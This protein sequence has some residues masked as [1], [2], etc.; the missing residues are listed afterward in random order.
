MAIELESC[1]DEPATIEQLRAAVDEHSR[2][3]FLD[4]VI[5]EAIDLDTTAELQ[6]R[7]HAL[8]DR[9]ATESEDAQRWIRGA[10]QYFIESNDAS[11][12]FV[13]G[14]LEDDRAVMD[15]V[16]RWLEGED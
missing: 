1:A 11:S 4:A 10:V 13:E 16:E 7:S 8:L 5:N 2:Q 14:G 6:R 9:C 3:L 12:D 15:A